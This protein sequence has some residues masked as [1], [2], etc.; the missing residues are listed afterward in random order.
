MI[1]R[2]FVA[3]AALW[4]VVACSEFQ[5]ESDHGN[6]ADAPLDVRVRMMEI[7]SKATQQGALPEGSVLGL[8]V[9]DASGLLYGGVEYQNVPYRSSEAGWQTEQAVMLSSRQGTLYA[10]WPYNPEVTSIHSVPVAL[11]TQIDYMFADPVAGL[12]KYNPRA[13]IFLRHALS[14]VRVVLVKGTYVGTGNVT[15]VSVSGQGLAVSAEMDGATG[16]LSEYEGFGQAV[17]VETDISLT[18]S[19][20]STEIILLPATDPV[21]ITFAIEVDGEEREV[22]AEDVSLSQGVMSQ[23]TLVVNDSEIVVTEVGMKDWAIDVKDH[24]VHIAGNTSGVAF[25]RSFSSDGSVTLMAVPVEC[26]TAVD[27]VA[28]EGTCEHEQTIDASTGIRTIVLRQLAEDVVLR[29]NGTWPTV[30]SQKFNIDSGSVGTSVRLFR[31]AN[32][33]RMAECIDYMSVDGMICPLSQTFVFDQPGVHQVDVNMPSD[34]EINVYGGSQKHLLSVRVPYCTKKLNDNAFSNSPLLEE[35]YLPG[36]VAEIDAYAFYNDYSLRTIQM[37]E[38]VRKIGYAAFSYCSSLV[39]IILPP[40]LE[41]IRNSA[42]SCCSSLVEIEIPRSVSYVGDLFFLCSSLRSV[43]FQ[44]DG[45]VINIQD[46]IARN[47]P[48]LETIVLPSIS[49]KS[50]EICVDCPKLKKIQVANERCTPMMSSGSSFVNVSPTGVLYV[51]E[52]GY[53]YETW[54]EELGPGWELRY[55]EE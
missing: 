31:D 42:F 1:K 19:P 46:N 52:G 48:S 8:S 9:E 32:Y 39:D 45:P 27:M 54:L 37:H 15:G 6:V 13:D 10:Y 35:I 43:V 53:G 2:M 47:C 49:L 44:S 22:T 25:S 17:A 12:S 55:I 20:Q 41:S 21:S 14:A 16:L 34:V 7:K 3:A 4:A 11:E 28:V 29:F 51:P 30:F 23:V 5:E 33:S 26:G 18:G 24:Q 38:G 36:S 50:S 40:G